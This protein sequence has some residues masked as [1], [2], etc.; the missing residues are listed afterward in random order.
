MEPVGMR[1]RHSYIEILRTIQRDQGIL[2]DERRVIIRGLH[3][4][5]SA[6]RDQPGPRPYKRFA[7][8]RAKGLFDPRIPDLGCGT[9]KAGIER[10][11]IFRSSMINFRHCDARSYSRLSPA[12]SFAALVRQQRLDDGLPDFRATIEA[13]VGEVDLRQAPVRFD[14]P[15]IHRNANAAWTNNEGRFDVIM[16]ADIGWHVGSSPRKHS[17][18]TLRTEH[19]HTPL[20]RVRS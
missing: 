6:E 11:Q 20:C 12:G 1:A 14:V 9:D 13:L 15:Q 2:I 19:Q 7:L 3:I 18:V 4:S 8:D 5:M 16:M 10:M 17:P